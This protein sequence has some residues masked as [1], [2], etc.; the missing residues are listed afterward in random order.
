MRSD[1]ANLSADIEPVLPHLNV[2][3][4]GRYHINRKLNPDDLAELVALY[5]DGA[6]MLE[7]SRKF[8][9]H[10]HTVVAHLR[11]AG[12]DVRPQKKM[13]PR[14]VTKAKQLYDD[15][16]SLAEVGK[17]FTT[18]A[19]HSRKWG[20]DWDSKPALSARRSNATVFSFGRRWRIAGMDHVT[21]EGQAARS[22]SASSS[23]P[24]IRLV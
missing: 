7:L 6:S 16:N 13:N 11:R 4:P 20:S 12:V 22:L 3:D 9:T 24:V 14:L 19:T 8:E 2:V 21:N 18:T 1:Q 17:R 10:R 5:E 15:G 23:S